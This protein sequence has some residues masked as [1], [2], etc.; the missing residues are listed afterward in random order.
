MWYYYK[1]NTLTC[2]INHV[3]KTCPIGEMRK[4]G[5]GGRRKERNIRIPRAPSHINLSFM[6]QV[7]GVG[8]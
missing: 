5:L 2:T 8:V 1:T 7:V 6:V 3:T 4:V